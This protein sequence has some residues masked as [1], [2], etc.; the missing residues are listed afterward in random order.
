MFPFNYF[1]GKHFGESYFTRTSSTEFPPWFV[2]MTDLDTAQQLDVPA[3]ARGAIIQ[4]D[5]QNV[6]Y[7]LDGG[8]PAAGVGLLLRTTD[9]PIELVGPAVKMARFLE[10][11]GGGKL[12]VQFK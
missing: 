8:V 2:Q 11:A 5:T 7:R 1:S 10:A 4:A 6:R 12:N 9:A 3:G